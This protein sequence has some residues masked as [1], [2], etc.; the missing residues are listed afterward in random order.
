MTP[1]DFGN[2]LLTLVSQVIPIFIKYN[3]LLLFLFLLYTIAASTP[4]PDANNS[5][6]HNVVFVW[7]PLS[8]AFESS[9]SFG[10]VGTFTADFNNSSIAFCKSLHIDQLHFV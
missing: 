10:L 7:S 9:V 8:G 5:E 3:Y 1:T 2:P 4:I 6:I